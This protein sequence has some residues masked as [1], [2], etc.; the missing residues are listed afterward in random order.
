MELKALTADL[1]ISSQILPHE[2]AAIKAAGLRA[3][4]CHRP[5][6]EVPDQ[7]PYANVASVAKAAGFEIRHQP[8]LSGQL[9]D[10]DAGRFGRL[11]AELP[12]PVPVYCRSGARSSA[13]WSMLQAENR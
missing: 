2:I 9:A 4:V 5:D 6:G 11:L 13:L 7:P 1:S 10:A 3:V 12:K 8:V